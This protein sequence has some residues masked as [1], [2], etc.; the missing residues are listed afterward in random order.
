MLL[1][2]AG[3]DV[4]TLHARK[5]VARIADMCRRLPLTIGVAG[6]L[7]RQAAR[8]SS[9]N[10]SA[11]S[12]WADVV[13]LLEEELD[14]AHSGASIEESVIRASL[15]AIPEKLRKQVSRLFMA[16][17]LVPEDTHVPLDVLGKIYDACGGGGGAA[18]ADPTSP[19]KPISRLH[20]RQYL[21]VLLDRSL[22]LGT[23]DRAQLHD[24]MLDYVLKEFNSEAQKEA[25]REFVELLRR[26][27][28]ST[29]TASGQYLRLNAHHHIKEAHDEEW[30]R[31][32]QAI[33]WIEDHVNG[34]SISP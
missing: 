2:A 23:I 24:V 17:A 30:A 20:V 19:A 25:Q 16:F 13:A 18:G 6:K 7:I 12:D 5:E 4:A 14:S 1:G 31:S 15:K 21:K 32:K 9:S 33:S 3:L 22:V 11:A 8:G 28:R 10:M 26:S 34:R 29:Y 27:D